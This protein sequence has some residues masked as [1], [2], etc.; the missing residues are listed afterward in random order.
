M[1]RRARLP[2]LNALRA[3]EAAGRHLS[4]SKAAEELS[5]TPAAVGHQIKVLEEYLGAPLFVRLNR[6]VELTAA[7]QSLLPAMSDAFARLGDAVETFQS[8]SAS[9]PL[10][11]SVE[12]AFGARWLLRRL[13]RFREGH[14]GVDVRIDATRRVVDFTREQVDLAIRYGSGDYPGLRVDCLFAEQVFPVCSPALLQG[15]HPLRT[16]RDLRHHTLLRHEWNPR[17][18]TWPDWDMW[19]KA[20][21]LDDIEPRHSAEFTG[22][23]RS[24]VLQAAAEGQGVALASSVLVADDLAAGRLVKPFDVTFPVSFCYYVVSPRAL[25][26]TPKVRAFREWL[27]SEVS[28]TCGVDA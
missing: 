3:F 24:F 23:T 8:R 10:T 11:V 9:R 4:F 15:R 6:A 12:P 27:L 25:A 26:D 1:H 19:L 22:E 16:P 7:G 28:A 5:V 21:A 20:A 14:P 18:P 13:D 17:Y 2:S